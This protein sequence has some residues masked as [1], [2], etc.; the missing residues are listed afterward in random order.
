MLFSLKRYPEALDNYSK[1]ITLDQMN[2]Q[3]YN[4]RGNMY[5]ILEDYEN[6][7]KDFNEA[8]SLVNNRDIFY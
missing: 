6:A 1:A 8:I 4:N 5:N 3:Y 7:L 2:A